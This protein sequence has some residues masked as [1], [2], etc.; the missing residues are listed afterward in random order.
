MNSLVGCFLISNDAEHSDVNSE[1]IGGVL[2]KR[3]ELKLS[4]QF[5]RVF[6]VKNEADYENWVKFLSLALD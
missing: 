5:K 4:Q 1:E 3:I 2:Y 6:Y